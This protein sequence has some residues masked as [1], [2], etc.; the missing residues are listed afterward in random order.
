[1]HDERNTEAS[2]CNLTEGSKEP[3]PCTLGCFFY[4]K[5]WESF[6]SIWSTTQILI[7][8]VSPVMLCLRNTWQKKRQTASI[9]SHSVQCK[10]YSIQ[11]LANAL[12]TTVKKK[13]PCS[14]SHFMN[15]WFALKLCKKVEI[16]VQ[17][18]LMSI[19]LPNEL[20]SEDILTLQF[21]KTLQNKHVRVVVL[22]L[23]CNLQRYKSYWWLWL[24][25]NLSYVF[26]FSH[27]AAVFALGVS[28]DA[29]PNLRAL[30]PKAAGNIRMCASMSSI[31][32][33][34]SPVSHCQL[35]AR[36]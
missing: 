9:S 6:K 26:I 32:L 29:A 24:N 11:S 34:T 8:N 31:R 3:R 7:H 15:D 30:R 36:K 10:R 13:Q 27:D 2:K 16:Q 25:V 33:N 18:S 22:I 1:M 23:Q 35:W 4:Q 21:L 28:L 14:K 20:A 12:G 5:T 17:K 19:L